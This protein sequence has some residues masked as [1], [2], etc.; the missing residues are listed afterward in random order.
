M[1]TSIE[2]IRNQRIGDSSR[3]TYASQ[4][5]QF[6]LYLWRNKRELLN[7]EFILSVAA[8]GETNAIS[9]KLLK[10]RL[11]GN[12]NNND[13]WPAPL[14]WSDMTAE[15]IVEWLLKKYD[16]GNLSKSQLNTR[17]S[18]VYCLFKDYGAS[19]SYADFT[20]ELSD[21][22]K[23][24]RRK[25][26][27]N[28]SRDGGEVREG[29]LPLSFNAYRAL[30]EALQS[31]SVALNWHCDGPFNHL[32]FVLMWNLMCRA[33]NCNMIRLEHLEWRNDA[34]VIFFSRQKTDQAGDKSKYPRH[35]YANPLMPEICPILALGVYWLSFG[36]EDGDLFSGRN[37]YDRFCKGLKQV[38]DINSE[39]FS[40]L[41]ISVSNIG[42]H[43][44]RKGSA[45]YCS[46]G[47][48][49]CPPS[50]AVNIRAG[51][52]LGGVEDTY[53]RYEAAGDQYVGRVTSGLPIVDASFMTL[54][55][56][57]KLYDIEGVR[58]NIGVVDKAMEIG[59]GKISDSLKL[60]AQNCLASV[61][62]HYDYLVRVLPARHRI[63]GNRILGD[64]RIINNL[65][66]HL[67]CGVAN[68]PIAVQQR[69][70]ATGIP[71]HVVLLSV[72]EAVQGTVKEVSPVLEAAI[73]KLPDKME[74][75]LRKMLEDGAIRSEHVTPSHLAHT[76]RACLL[77]AGFIP[78]EQQAVAST[79]H[80]AN[81][82]NVSTPVQH[83]MDDGT[84]SLLSSSFTIPSMKV[85][86]AWIRWVVGCDNLG[87]WMFIRTC[88]V[89]TISK[90][91]WKKYKFLMEYIMKSVRERS[92][93]VDNCNAEQARSMY[94][95]VK[96][97]VQVE[98]RKH[99]RR[100]AQLTWS[101][102]AKNLQANIALRRRNNENI[103]ND[104]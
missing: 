94:R 66:Q 86:F 103:N 69:F 36:I 95:Q 63:F 64:K 90:R 82:V 65:K 56:A 12:V 85:E 61:V 47:S 35:V 15:V 25:I 74:S 31:Q 58:I 46:S 78:N 55:P 30:G 70:T 60:V 48:T 99:R 1:E 77:D 21:L 5:A 100:H 97:C 80:P 45:T 16:E 24:L 26:S 14:K 52:T 68:D 91:Q 101:T 2:E 53:K 89:P 33:S 104:E 54:P 76:I 81:D 4:I 3:V 37:Q 73:E 6:L 7:S 67:W 20:H 92:L 57:F 10:T 96:A 28:R 62:Y 79:N 59:F 75:I 23:G 39:E 41:G 42:A 32:Y 50:A 51:W 11:P 93:W 18:A 17:R 72:M 71:P 102:V 88:D 87:P 98:G 44:C 83:R 40:L 84:L 8:E 49:A 29:K 9:I 13:K 22:C 27:D 34:L 19:K 43:S 38:I